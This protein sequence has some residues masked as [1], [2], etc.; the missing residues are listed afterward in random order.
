MTVPGALA[1]GLSLVSL[2]AQP[3]HLVFQDGRSNEQ[4]QLNGQTV[5]GILHDWKQFIPVGVLRP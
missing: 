3:A 2:S 4:A 5:R 1:T